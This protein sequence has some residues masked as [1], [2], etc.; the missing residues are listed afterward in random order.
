MGHTI[1]ARYREHA[2]HLH[3]WQSN[4]STVA[5]HNIETGHRINFDETIVLVR[6]TG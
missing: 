3:L 6:T 5:Q 4:K 2:C 1:E